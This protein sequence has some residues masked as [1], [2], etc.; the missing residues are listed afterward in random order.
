MTTAMPRSAT[1]PQRG[2]STF[3]VVLIPARPSISRAR[4]ARSLVQ[5]GEPELDQRLQGS[6]PISP[7]DLLALISFPSGIG[8]RDL[9]DPIAAAQHFGGDFRFE[10]ELVGLDG[11]PVE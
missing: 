4:R 5:P 7:G 1:A 3:S 8:D 2:S 9:V 10:V 11:D 6:E